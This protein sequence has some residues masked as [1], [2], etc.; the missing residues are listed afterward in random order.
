MRKTGTKRTTTGQGVD[1]YKQMN[2]KLWLN[3]IKLDEQPHLTISEWCHKHIKELHKEYP[4]EE[5]LALC[6]IEKRWP[7]DF[8]LVDMIHPEQSTSTGAVTATDDGMEWAVKE[9]QER[10]EDMWLWNCVLH[11]HHGMS[12]FWSGTD[13]NARKSLNDGRFMAFAVVTAYSK[14]GDDIEVDYKGCVNF[15]KPYNI[16]IDC[17]MYYEDGYLDDDYNKYIDEYLKTRDEIFEEKVKAKQDEMNWLMAQPDYSRVLDYLWLDIKDKLDENYQEVVMKKMP[18]PQVETILRAC[19]NEAKA[20]AEEKLKTNKELMDGMAEYSAW[21]SWSGNLKTQLEDHKKIKPKVYSWWDDYRKAM[22]VKSEFSQSNRF[23]DDL[24]PSFDDDNDGR[25][26]RFNTKRY[27]TSEQLR[28]QLGLRPEVSIIQVNWNWKVYSK[29]QNRYVYADDFDEEE[30]RESCFWSEQ[31]IEE[32]L[33]QEQDKKKDI[34]KSTKED[35]NIRDSEGK[36]PEELW[37]DVLH[38]LYN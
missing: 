31:E 37:E 19:E 38:W 24:D 35:A 20:E 21:S 8:Y 30:D 26:F 34:E 7:W 32:H 4:R 27:P 9:L 22:E 33:Q 12:C 18:N 10:W 23:F 13:D 1:I 2:D 17:D 15:Y 3:N 36:T 14:K 6:K 25:G 16:E 28:A 29:A 11:S 5:R